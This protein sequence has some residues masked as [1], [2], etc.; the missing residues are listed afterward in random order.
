MW[1]LIKLEL[2][3]GRFDSYVW[4]SIVTYVIIAGLAGIMYFVGGS[5]LEEP[6]FTTIPEMLAF[7]DLM[8][9][10]TFIIYASVLL[11]K[12]V[13]NEFKDKTI[14]L[15]FSYPISRKK[16]IFVKLA[17]VFVWTFANVVIA[18]LLIDALF[19]AINSVVGYIPGSLTTELLFSHGLHVL[20]QAFGAAGMSL[21][22]LVIGL[23]KKSVPMTIISSIVIVLLVCS[24][25]SG[26]TLSSIIA[27][28]L[29]L[30]VLG[31]IITCFSFRNIDRVDVG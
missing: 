31:I 17:M 29:S 19:V 4:G 15:M 7:I 10:A 18:N 20:M 2:K 28:P 22:P 6:D 9:R 30:S 21:L 24:N 5:G 27:I 14:A 25:N 3:K 16:L 8:V 26:F 12:L 23:P 1:Q 11:S 13:I